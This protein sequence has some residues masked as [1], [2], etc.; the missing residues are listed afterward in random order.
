MTIQLLELLLYF[1]GSVLGVMLIIQMSV[2]YFKYKN[3]YFGLFTLSY[4]GTSLLTL[5][6]LIYDISSIL[7]LPFNNKIV[8]F[9]EAI[10]FPIII[11]STT[12]VILK[13][14]YENIRTSV[15]VSVYV[16]SV[17]PSLISCLS[18]LDIFNDMDIDNLYIRIVLVIDCVLF[19]WK[20]KKI[21]CD[22]F[23]KLGITLVCVLSLYLVY[24]ILQEVIPKFKMDLFPIV[25][26][27]WSVQLI[28]F[29]WKHFM[30]DSID[31]IF[32]IK[33]SFI[34][35]Y[36][37]TNREQEIIQLIQ[38]GYTNSAISKKLFLSEKTVANHIYNIYK[39][40]NIKSRFEL[41]CLFKRQEGY[42]LH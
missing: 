16:L 39:K 34:E 38:E 1:I 36:N 33:E 28:I 27:F 41:I 29:S 13:I 21:N 8:M 6:Y 31:T 3:V 23:R 30:Q 5:F 40:L 37:I 20:F 4:V 14:F 35:K 42:C 22:S 25:Y 12:M 26:L 19:L 18:I 9:G 32:D 11:F 15:I 7:S 17:L 2:V 24:L 10:A